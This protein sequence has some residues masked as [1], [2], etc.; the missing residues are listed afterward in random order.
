MKYLLTAI[1]ITAFSFTS[2][3][4]QNAKGDI[5]LSVQAAPLVTTIGSNNLG[6]IG[7]L[8][9]EF[10]VANKFSAGISFFTSNNTVFKND[11]DVTANGYG[12]IPT[13][14]YYAFNKERFDVFVQL[15]YGFG[16]ED[17]TRNQI[18]NS[19]LTIFTIG[20]GGQY[21]FNEN[22]SFRMLIPYFD[23]KNVTLNVTAAQGPTGFLGVAYRI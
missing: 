1:C 11:N 7:L 19:A 2:L 15:G 16:F 12:I 22:W 10:F 8:T 17:F 3:I 21:H 18:Q 23:A 5:T 20:V 13:L 9:S 6:A 4:A 14:Q